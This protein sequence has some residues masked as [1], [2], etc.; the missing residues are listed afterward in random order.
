[1]EMTQLNTRIPVELK[2][3]GDEV[4]ARYGKTASDV[5][6]AVWTYM[7]ETQKIP[8]LVNKE[9]AGSPEIEQKKELAQKASN[10][11]GE[12]LQEYGLKQDDS[13]FLS[14]EEL[15]EQNYFEMLDEYEALND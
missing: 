2:R 12:A 15:R 1:M 6:R 10:L 3:G 7:V 9:T 13:A 14:A 8:E 4:L 11:L 5:M